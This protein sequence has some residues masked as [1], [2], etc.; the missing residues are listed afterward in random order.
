MA[1]QVTLSFEEMIGEAKEVTRKQLLEEGG[2]DAVE[3]GTQWPNSGSR[4]RCNR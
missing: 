4:G 2:E 1:E 3:G